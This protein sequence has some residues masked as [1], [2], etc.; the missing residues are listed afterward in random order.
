VVEKCAGRLK[1]WRDVT[2]RYEKRAVHYRAMV[3][4]TSLKLWL[5]T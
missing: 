4:V 2:T 3:V 5:P 1:Q